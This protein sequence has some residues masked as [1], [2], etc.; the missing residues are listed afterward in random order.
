[1]CKENLKRC[2]TKENIQIVN[3]CYEKGLLSHHRNTIKTTY[4]IVVDMPQND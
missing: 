2:F 4:E 1:M 3:E